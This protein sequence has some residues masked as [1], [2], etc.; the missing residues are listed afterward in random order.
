MKTGLKKQEKTTDIWFDEK[1]PLNMTK[2]SEELFNGSEDNPS[3]PFQEVFLTSEIVVDE[4]EE[5]QNLLDGYIRKNLLCRRVCRTVFRLLPSMMTV[6][7]EWAKTST[8][9]HL[10]HRFVCREF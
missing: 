10:D 5:K 2:L 6:F 8:V 7:S 4:E 9:I 1:D 3:N